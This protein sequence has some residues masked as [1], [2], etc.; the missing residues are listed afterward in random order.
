MVNYID[1]IIPGPSEQEVATT[2]DMLVTQMCMKECGINL[3]EIQRSSTSLKFLGVQWYGTCR[4]IPS[5]V[6]DNLLHLAPPTIKKEAQC[7]VGLFGF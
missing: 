3:T 7:L 2:L 6:K 5:K 4:G 1:D